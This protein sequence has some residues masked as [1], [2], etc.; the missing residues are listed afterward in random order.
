M[1]AETGAGRVLLLR[2]GKAETLASGLDEPY[3]LALWPPGP[4][5]RFLYVAATDRVVRFPLAPEELRVVGRAQ[6]VVPHLPEG[7]HWTRDIAFSPD[8]TRMFVAVG[9]A[10]N[11]APD[12]EPGRAE[13]R[14][15]DPEGRGEHSFAQ[16]LRNP[17]S[18]VVLPDGQVWVTVNERDGL[19]DNLPPDYVTRVAEDDHFGWPW[20]YTGS[21]PDPRVHEPPPG[22]RERVRLPDVLIQ[23]H[24]APLGLALYPPDGPLA[25]WR[26][27]L[28]AALHGS[29][30]R[31]QR[32]GY[33]VIRIP[34]ENG[35]ALGWYEDVLTGFVVDDD[36]VWGR[37]TGVAVDE[38]GAV[39][40]SEDA[41]G[42]VWRMT[43]A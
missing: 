4:A 42:T 39:W 43:P 2:D 37:P 28:I 6:P 20:F 5:P 1:L 38:A 15:Y 13:I 36:S 9:S 27:S 17:V 33:K 10:G 8:G 35:R 16:G 30:N 34:I 3:G 41:N 40:V 7:G 31:A 22:L 11:I 19:G 21:N 12:A 32:T 29:W 24:S 18:L 25:A 26:G 14:T 23:P